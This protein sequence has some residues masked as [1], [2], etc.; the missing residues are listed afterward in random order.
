MDIVSSWQAI[1][2]WAEV[3]WTALGDY[4]SRIENWVSAGQ[5]IVPILISILTFTLMT[6]Q[7]ALQLQSVKTQLIAPVANW[8]E[9]A[10]RTLAQCR[11]L[12]EA[13]AG[14]EAEAFFRQRDSLLTSLSTEVDLGRLYFP[15]IP[16]RDFGKDKEFAFRGYRPPIL[17]AMMFAYHV[18]ESLKPSSVPAADAEEIFDKARRIV[19][20]ELRRYTSDEI[21]LAGRRSARR[22]RRSDDDGHKQVALLAQL[23]ETHFPGLLARKDYVSWAEGEAHHDF[24]RGFWHRLALGKRKDAA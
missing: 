4:F 12:A 24:G 22:L 18:L 9:R 8:G 2:E 16:S 6:R 11:R 3:V 23:L 13:N 19:I 14:P 5:A 17:D 1:G 15:N 7:R 20:S 10:I 21:A